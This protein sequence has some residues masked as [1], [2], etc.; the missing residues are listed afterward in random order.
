MLLSLILVLFS[1]PLWYHSYSVSIFQSQSLVFLPSS[2]TSTS[3][4]SSLP[5]MYFLNTIFFF[6]QSNSPS[7]YLLSYSFI[8]YLLDISSVPDLGTGGNLIS[9]IHKI[10]VMSLLTLHWVLL[11][12]FL[13][14]SWG[15]DYSLYLYKRSMSHNL[16]P[17]HVSVCVCVC[18]VVSDSATPWTVAW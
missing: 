17:W 1:S 2:K 3:F 10:C 9:E 15:V 5:E 4:L 14:V 16:C 12:H 8:N 7:I 11:Y 18:S 13:C 6:N